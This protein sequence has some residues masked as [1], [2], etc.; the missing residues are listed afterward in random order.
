VAGGRSRNHQTAGAHL[1]KHPV[2][3]ADGHHR[4][5]TGLALR[6]FLKEKSP[7][8]AQGSDHI[9]AYFTRSKHPGLTIFPYHRLLHNLP[10]RRF[11]G[12]LK[13]LDAHFQVERPLLPPSPTARPAASSWPGWRTGAAPGP[14][15]P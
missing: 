7:L 13:K 11:S 14:S 6:K 9:M 3:I 10:K 4:Y 12:L 5:E 1:A 2:Y 15:S 8:F